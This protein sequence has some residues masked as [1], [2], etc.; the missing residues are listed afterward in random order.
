MDQKLAV[1]GALNAPEGYT[2]LI[3]LQTGGGKSLVTQTISYQKDGLT[4]VIVPT[5]SLAIDQ[6]RVT[7][8]V[9]KKVNNEEEIFSYSSGDN[10]EPIFKAIKDKKA[11]VLFISPEALLENSGFAEVIKEANKSRYLKI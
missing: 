9:I 4:I 5:I 8:K 6:E 10:T 2:V 7:K 11:K 3:S 1:Y